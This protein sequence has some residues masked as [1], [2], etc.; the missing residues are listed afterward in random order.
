MKMI[1]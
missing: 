1:R